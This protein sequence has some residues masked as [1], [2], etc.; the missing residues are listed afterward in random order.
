MDACIPL[1]V[2]PGVIL[3]REP[4][5]PAKATDSAII[6]SGLFLMAAKDSPTGG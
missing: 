3:L 2:A 5:S 4:I 1:T 6:A